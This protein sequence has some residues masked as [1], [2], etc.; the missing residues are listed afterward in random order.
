MQLPRTLLAASSLFWIPACSAFAQEPATT[1][2]MITDSGAY[3]VSAMKARKV[4]RSR[5]EPR[6]EAAPAPSSSSFSSRGHTDFDPASVEADRAGKAAKLALA[7]RERERNARIDP[8]STGCVIKP[9][10]TNADMAAC[11]AD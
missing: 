4:Q 10:M 8:G 5:S 6:I 11:R 2:T 1:G 7:E 9:V 3:R